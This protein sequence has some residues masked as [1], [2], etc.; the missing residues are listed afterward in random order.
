MAVTPEIDELLRELNQRDDDVVQLTIDL[1]A[2]PSP[3]PPGDE[4]AR[5]AERAP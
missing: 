2:A 4:T 1:I 3:N 5:Q